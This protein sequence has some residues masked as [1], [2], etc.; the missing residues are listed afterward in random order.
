[1]T[2]EERLDNY[3][4]ESLA[5]HR[6]RD[7]RS[8]K[9]IHDSLWGTSRYYP[10]ELVIIDS[11]IFQRLR[12]IAQT[13]LASVA[14]PS[15]NHSRFEHSLGVATVVKRFVRKLQERLGPKTS[16]EFLVRKIFRRPWRNYGSPR[17]FT[18]LG[19]D[20]FPICQRS[21]CRRPMSSESFD[22]GLISIQLN[23]ARSLPI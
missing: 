8:S 5:N 1:M 18:T 17:C 19:T 22:K 11:P 6:P 23:P 2:F 15:L 4:K 20:S 10:H 9:I 14:Y 3:V 12:R 21:F 7:Y 16:N 13:G